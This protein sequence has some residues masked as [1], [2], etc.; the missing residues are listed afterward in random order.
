MSLHDLLDVR[1]AGPNFVIGA[2]I[3]KFNFTRHGWINNAQDDSAECPNIH[4]CFE[5]MRSRIVDTVQRGEILDEKVRRN[6]DRC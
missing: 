1:G 4:V 5:P 6:D 3:R 2:N